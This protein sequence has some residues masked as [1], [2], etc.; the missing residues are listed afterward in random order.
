MTAART[1]IRVADWTASGCERAKQQVHFPCGAAA[2]P[3]RI[4]GA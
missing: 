1:M 3:W 4:T 2:A